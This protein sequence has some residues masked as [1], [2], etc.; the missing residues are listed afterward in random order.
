MN[1][2]DDAHRF[3]FVELIEKSG[4]RCDRRVDGQ[5]ATAMSI[6]STEAIYPHAVNH[7]SK[8]GIDFKAIKRQPLSDAGLFMTAAA[9][10]LFTGVGA[11]NLD[12][13]TILDS[14]NFVTVLRAMQFRVYGIGYAPEPEEEMEMDDG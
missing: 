9:E 6:L 7:I 8:D 13:I 3:R 2:I 14:E 12:N 5:Y 10:N 1:F 11:V 4:K